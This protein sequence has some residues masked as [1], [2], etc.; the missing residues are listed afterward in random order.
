VPKRVS[1][2]KKARFEVF[3]RDSFTCQ[4]CGR[5][6]PAVVLEIDH[7]IPICSAGDSCEENLITACFDCNRGKAGN[8]LLDVPQ[9]IQDRAEQ[10]EEAESQISEYTRMLAT[11]KRRENKCIRTLEKLF[12]ETFENQSFTDKFKRDIRTSFLTKMLSD[13]IEDAMHMACSRIND[14][15]RAISYFCGICWHKIRSQ[16]CG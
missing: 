5:T 9:S 14:P 3:K 11:K 2:G 7:I 13:E 10:M 12:S 16:N 6:P 4:Y 8:S 15:D 1:I